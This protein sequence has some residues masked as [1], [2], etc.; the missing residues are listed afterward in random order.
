MRSLWARVCFEQKNHTKAILAA[1][2]QGRFVQAPKGYVLALDN[3]V[4]GARENPAFGR[5][6]IRTTLDDEKVLHVFLLACVAN[7]QLQ[8]R[9]LVGHPS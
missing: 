2:N 3:G 8:F 5:V 1:D 7:E 9:K 4:D 6:P